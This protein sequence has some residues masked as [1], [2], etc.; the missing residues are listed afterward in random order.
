MDVRQTVSSEV[1]H[2]RPAMC[3]RFV[4]RACHAE[5]RWIVRLYPRFYPECITVHPHP[6]PLPAG[7]HAG[8]E[9]LGTGGADGRGASEQWHRRGVAEGAAG[10][11]ARDLGAAHHHVR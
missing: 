2:R 6:D 10:N 3:L 7:F 8:V 1:L 5:S 11:V 4:H 9:L